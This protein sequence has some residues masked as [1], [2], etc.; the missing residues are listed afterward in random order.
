M[1]D[2][3]WTDRSETPRTDAFIDTLPIIPMNE[4]PLV[5]AEAMRVHMLAWADFARALERE[6]NHK[7]WPH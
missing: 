2:V 1:V 4:G 7:V 5:A 3:G 6:V